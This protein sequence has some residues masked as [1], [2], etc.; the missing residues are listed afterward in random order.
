MTIEEKRIM[1]SQAFITWA[2]E[3]YNNKDMSLHDENFKDIFTSKMIL[4]KFNKFGINIVLPDML[5][6]I[7]YIC[8]EGNPGQFQVILKDLLNNIKQR[9]GPIQSGYV[10]TTIDFCMCFMTNFPI[11]DIESINDKYLKLWD[12]Q[13]KPDEFDSC[14]S[15]K[16]D[17]LCDTV[18]WWKE[19]ME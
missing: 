1:C 17:N 12:A 18:E 16:S 4:D 19:V 5:L 15:F 8:T 13:K 2:S 3:E 6:F 11:T 10:I 14:N 9:R 7:F